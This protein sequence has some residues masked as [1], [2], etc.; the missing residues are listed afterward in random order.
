MSPPPHDAKNFCS[1]AP[2]P[3]LQVWMRLVGKWWKCHILLI[4]PH[5]Q[6]QILTKANNFS[7][8]YFLSSLTAFLKS[9]DSMT[10]SCSWWGVLN[11]TLTLQTSAYYRCL[12]GEEWPGRKC[13]GTRR[14]LNITWGTG[15]NHEY[16]LYFQIVRQNKAGCFIL[17][18]EFEINIPL[19][20]LGIFAHVTRPS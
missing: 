20:L 7:V 13:P 8:F 10:M 1:V 6:I 17:W 15:S 5:I 2:Y 19:M 16:F 18:E 9:E 3:C 14:T 4:F 11:F 12:L